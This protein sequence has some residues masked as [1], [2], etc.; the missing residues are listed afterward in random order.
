MKPLFDTDGKC[1][2]CRYWSETVARF[3]ADHGG[4]EAVCLRPDVPEVTTWEG[5]SCA[6]YALAHP[7][8][9]ALDNPA[10]G[11]LSEDAY[12][13]EAAR[14]GWLVPIAQSRAAS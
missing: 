2:S 3:D 14:L 7:V 1:K 9:G 8:L 10:T 11:G 6:R 12:E 5:H 13:R 4:L